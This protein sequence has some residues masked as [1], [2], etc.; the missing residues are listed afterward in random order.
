VT[1]GTVFRV[2]YRNFLSLD[3][4]LTVTANPVP[5][6]AEPEKREFFMRR[7]RSIL[8]L[9]LVFIL[10]GVVLSLE[11][12]NIISGVSRLWPVF[13]LIVGAGFCILF[14]ERKAKDLAL[15][16]LGSA[17]C[18]LS[19][20]FFYLNYTS[21][22]RLATLWP[23]FLCIAGV[24]FLSIYL[25]SRMRLFS[26]LGVSLALLAAVFYLVFGVSHNLWP[27]SFVAFGGSL[28]VVNHYYL[29]K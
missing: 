22:A 6:C 26:I 9:A 23:V 8:I 12:M 5:A 14:F 10:A 18:Q 19:V 25:S 7:V 4:I 3:C 1:H 28:L 15:L 29:R 24:S 21:W 27:L 13:P 20:F 11:N 17:L 16:Y 2:T